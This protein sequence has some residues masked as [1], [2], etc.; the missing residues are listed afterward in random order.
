MSQLP[1]T[2]D[3]LRGPAAE[4]G[5]NL[6]RHPDLTFGASDRLERPS[7]Q[8]QV[9]TPPPAP[10]ASR[11]RIWGMA[12]VGIA[13][14]AVL[15]GLIGVRVKEKLKDRSAVQET[16]V[17]DQKEREERKQVA[18]VRPERATYAPVVQATGTLVPFE[19][20]DL[21]FKMGGRLWKVRV[22]VGDQVKAGELLAIVEANEASA[23]AA[24]AAAG[25][26]AAEIGLEM[27]KDVKRRTDLLFE[28][29]TIS[30]VEKTTTDQRT[31]L[32]E[33]QLLQA[34]AQARL[35]GASVG[36]A[37]LKAPFAGLITRV[38]PGI[39]RIVGPGEPIFH[40]EN[41]TVL[42]LNATLSEADARLVEVGAAIE[43]EGVPGKVTAVLPS[44]D[45]MTRRVPLVAEI[46]NTAKPPLLARAF[47]RATIKT[48]KEV[49]VL[50]LPGSA[51]KPGS[52]DEVVC[53]VEGKVVIKHVVFSI[54]ADGSALVR[55]GLSPEDVVVAQP[56][57]EMTNG[58]TIAVAAN[59]H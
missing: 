45:A 59:A 9:H 53:V 19:E 43:V 47:V 30:E 10:P 41:T 32:A 52:Q 48:G 46:S 57:G 16:Q 29:G 58:Q 55:E 8:T 50:K 13:A 26:Q 6:A 28:K 35:A 27:A 7:P 24:A 3:P 44:L 49:P 2:T 11:G 5:M 34:K 12:I 15:G 38:P 4:H 39:G 36:N 33:A 22:Q 18:V 23:Q 40:V 54:A 14:L 31:K 56:S 21:G 42:K 37:V 20:A 1:H 25:V 17:A 51:I